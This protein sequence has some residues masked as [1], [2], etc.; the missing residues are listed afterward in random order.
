MARTMGVDQEWHRAVITRSWAPCE[1][2]PEGR[3][4]TYVRGPY[5]HI[6]QARAAVTRAERGSEHPFRQP[7]SDRP[8]VFGRVERSTTVWETVE[9]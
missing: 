8:V 4:E 1:R 2:Y 6:G 5:E 9:D 7:R 3:I